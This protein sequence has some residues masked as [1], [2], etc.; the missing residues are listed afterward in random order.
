MRTGTR[1]VDL[2]SFFCDE[3]TCWSRTKGIFIFRDPFHISPV[4]SP[5]LV[6]GLRSGLDW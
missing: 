4:F 5:E 6:D 3:N 2:L 1:T